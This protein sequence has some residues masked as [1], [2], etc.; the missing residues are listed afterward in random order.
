MTS[1]L[2]KIPVIESKILNRRHQP[3]RFSPS[4]PTSLA[5]KGLPGGLI[6]QL[7][8]KLLYSRGD[9]IAGD[10]SRAIGLTFHLLDPII[11]RFKHE[12]LIQVKSSLGYGAVSSLLSLTETGRRVARDHLEKSLYTGPA[13][14][15]VKQYSAAVEAQRLPDCWLSPERLATAYSHMVI[16]DNV[17]QQIGPAV[18]AGKSFLIYGQP[19]NGKTYTAEAIANI[20]TSDVFL[21]YALE[22]QGNIHPAV[23]SGL[24]PHRQ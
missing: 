17:L 11:D 6:E 1:S 2:A 23:R 8:L 12:H 21:P 24:S 7:I 20:H 4:V 3:Q 16:S 15:P 10:V 18:N 19:G 5:D 14:V 13:P 22:C 9:T